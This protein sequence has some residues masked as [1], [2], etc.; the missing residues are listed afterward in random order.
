[1]A[2][3]AALWSSQNL[4]ILFPHRV[5]FYNVFI[6]NFAFISAYFKTAF[7]FYFSIIIKMIKSFFRFPFFQKREQNPP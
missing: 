5:N 4:E 7:Y 1:M 6:L 2:L 3:C